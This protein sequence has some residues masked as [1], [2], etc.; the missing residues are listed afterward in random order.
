MNQ[1]ESTI[2][3]AALFPGTEIKKKKVIPF[4][5]AFCTVLLLIIVAPSPSGAF[6]QPEYQ[7]RGLINCLDGYVPQ[8]GFIY[9]TYFNNFKSV[10]LR[11]RSHEA[12]GKFKLS[13]NLNLHQFIYI[14]KK[15]VLGGNWG[16]ETI[17]PI[18]NGHL[19]TD[20]GRCHDSGLG[21]VFFSTFV[22]SELKNLTIG[23]Y[24]IPFAWRILGGVFL[25]TGDY[26]HNKSFNVG[27][28]IT[29]F[30]L[31]VSATAFLT[32]RWAISS[33]INY[34]FHTKNS[35]YG[36]DKDDLKPG[37]LCNA[38][39]SSSYEIKPGIRIGGCGVVW[40]Q[41]TD[42]TLN[43]HDLRGRETALSFGPAIMLSRNFLNT[44]VSLICHGLFDTH[45]RNRPKGNT[46]QA[47]LIFMF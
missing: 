13:V 45:V 29:T 9:Q 20:A 1:L 12:P 43:G 8:Q 6:F 25:P 3:P 18:L 44:N 4:A 39:F 37:Q 24:T 22:Q 35:S 42:D 34:N 17:I 46:F 31:Y 14:T 5:F 47:R 27:S 21:D 36:P 11:K 26:D 15:K 28:H 32:Q 7:N 2:F 23:S 40:R 10:D 30:H 38:I 33:R 16:M 19:T 41:T